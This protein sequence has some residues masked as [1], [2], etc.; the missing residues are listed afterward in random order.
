MKVEEIFQPK[1]K[2]AQI[3]KE[4]EEAE[5]GKDPLVEYWKERKRERSICFFEEKPK[6][7]R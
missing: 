4:W 3:A 5:R 6:S 2:K 1:T 7:T